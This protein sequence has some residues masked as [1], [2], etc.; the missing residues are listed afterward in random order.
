MLENLFTLK[1][2]SE[3][4]V[5]DIFLLIDNSFVKDSEATNQLLTL[6]ENIH[7]LSSTKSYTKRVNLN[8]YYFDGFDVKKFS[9]SDSKIP[10]FKKIKGLSLINKAIEQI[11][12][13][14]EALMKNGFKTKPWFFCFLNG[15]SIGS[16][17]WPTFNHLLKDKKI[18]FRGFIIGSVIKPIALQSLIKTT[19]FLSIKPNKIDRAFEFIF[20]QAQSRIN[21][22]NQ[23]LSLPS[24]ET[25]AE[26][27]DMVTK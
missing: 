11:A 27:S 23:P 10:D 24:K 12:E 14:I 17:S 7:S 4:L 26:W 18:F 21:N 8:W 15:F 16:T 19:V 25:F 20:T 13:D 5:Q 22:P 9:N 2:Q 1:P 3:E 6:I